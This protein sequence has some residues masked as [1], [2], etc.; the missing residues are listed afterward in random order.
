MVMHT[1]AKVNEVNYRN[2]IPDSMQWRKKQDDTT[3]SNVTYVLI[4]CKRL[5]GKSDRH[6]DS[7]RVVVG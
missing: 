5:A 1:V 3:V 6:V 7:Y 2:L 4:L